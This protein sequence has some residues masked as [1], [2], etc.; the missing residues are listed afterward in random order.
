MI[1]VVVAGMSIAFAY[2]INYVKDYQTGSGASVME[3]ISIEDVW[4]MP[5]ST[6]KVSLFNYGK[7]ATTVNAFYVNG[8]QQPGFSPISISIG[9]HNVSYVLFA[10]SWTHGIAYDFKF[11]TARG[12]GFEGEYVS[13]NV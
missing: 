9:G 6:V 12:T 8:Q 1:M 5:N 3:L 7:V 4:F 13:P 2:F 10:Q 11:V